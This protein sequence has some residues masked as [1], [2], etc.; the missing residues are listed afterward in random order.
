MGVVSMTSWRDEVMVGSG[1][2]SVQSILSMQ[3][4]YRCPFLWWGCIH[5]ALVLTE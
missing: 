5:T 4:A 1:F 2:D 3:H